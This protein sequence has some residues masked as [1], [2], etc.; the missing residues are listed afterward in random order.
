MDIL[1]L[2]TALPSLVPLVKP[3]LSDR[4]LRIIREGSPPYRWAPGIIAVTA[5]LEI[6]L[7]TQFPESRKYAP[8]DCLEVTNNDSVDL[9]LT[10]NSN[11]AYPVPAGVIRKVDDDIGIHSVR[12]TNLDTVTA[13][14]AGK[15]VVNLKRKPLDADSAARSRYQ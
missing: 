4:A 9:T 5:S 1:G 2:I 10:I 7:D 12:L 8:L 6:D 13:T 14:T 15:I 11:E 3:R